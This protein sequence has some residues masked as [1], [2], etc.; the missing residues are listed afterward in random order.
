MEN[1]NEDMAI[2]KAI[3]FLRKGSIVVEK[4]GIVISTL[5]G[6]VMLFAILTGVFTRYFPFMTTVIWSEE[7]ARMM[8]L[9]LTTTGGSVAFSRRELVNF[10]LIIDALPERGRKILTVFNSIFVLICLGVLV[11]F[12][13]DML[14]LKAK[15]TASA[16]K[17]SYFWWALGFYIGFVL[18]VWHAVR[19]LVEDVYNLFTDKSKKTKEA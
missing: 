19:H 15:V 13:Y 9:W 4:I 1:R 2:P 14:L 11:Y 17:I 10:N 3:T 6:F 12:G 18:M 8:M 16:T 7:V 5:A